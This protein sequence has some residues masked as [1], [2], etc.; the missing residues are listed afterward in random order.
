M[1]TLIQDLR[2]AA[3][4]LGNAPGFTAI[5]V[6]TLALG[7]GAVTAVFSVVNTV[8]LK[9]LPY[10]QPDR[11]V[12]VYQTFPSAAGGRGRGGVSVPN[13]RDWREQAGSL[14][15]L[16]AYAPRD[17][18][19]QGVDQ[20]QRLS[21]VA[22]SADLF[23]VLEA[24]PQLGRTF[25]AGE[26]EP[27][28][29]RA[30][31]LSDGF[32]RQRFDADPGIVGREL[33]LDGTTHTVVGVM[34]PE[35]RFPAA[36]SGVHLWV[37]LIAPPERVD[38]RGFNWLQVVGRL[39]PGVEH[40]AAQAEMDDVAR[41]IGE[42]DPGQE[43]VGVLILP[44][45]DVTVAN[46]RPTLLMLLGAAGLVLLIAGANTASLMLARSSGRRRELAVRAAL[47]ATPG[48]M[49]RQLL[50]ESLLLASAGGAAGLLL[51]SYA[52]RGMLAVAGGRLPRA[53]DMSLDMG[54]FAF[55]MVLSVACAVAFALLPALL[56]R[57][58][59]LHD[60]L[61]E[62]G[63]RG[64][65][66]GGGRGGNRFRGA[67]VVGQ[68]A[69]SLVLL[70]GAGLLVRT[71][72]VLLGT[73][74]GMR[75][76][77]VLTMHVAVPGERYPAGDMV[78]RFHAPALEQVQALPGV[79]AVGW[80]SHLPLDEWG[81][82]FWFEIPGRPAPA[83]RADQPFAEL[84][85]VSAGYFQALGI[86]VVQGRDLAPGDGL[87]DPVVLI[88]ST[89]ARRYFPD[90]DPTTQRIGIPGFAPDGGVAEIPIVGVVGDVRQ[91]ELALDP[92][93]EVYF[94]YDLASVLGIPK[95][96]LVVST[97]VPA[98]ILT[99]AVRRAIL[100]V[101]PDQ[102][103]YNVQTMEQ[104]VT[105]S[106]GDRRLYLWLLGAFALVALALAVAGIYGVM[107]YAVTQRTRE[108]SVRMALGA[109]P[110]GVRGLVVRQAAMLALLGVAVGV[111]AALGL[112]RLLQGLLHGVG[113]ADPVT[114][115]VVA[116]GLLAVALAAGY[117]PARRAS[118]VDPMVALRE[119]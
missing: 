85:L 89:L 94:P 20:P 22:V 81:T 114:F 87:H 86:P 99:G 16:A 96:T 50:V 80:T 17:A 117:L 62:G 44:L 42:L 95:F 70:V 75:T 84:R 102:P 59:R 2:Y 5:V 31:V 105:G 101:D 14:E 104:V 46:V 111:P 57:R 69:L 106:I 28:A 71:V 113:P 41:R 10:G 93:P 115:A 100:A 26:D 39:G 12:Q 25:L 55:L 88:N 30:V 45:T 79:R 8:L 64:G 18:N 107:S 48:R 21:T 76:E 61:K 56:A 74:T 90:D 15:S 43:E 73:E 19:L 9:P 51:A 109:S 4:S 92:M 72:S 78:Q 82:N 91:A 60:D 110:G 13:F 63:A 6:L 38:N 3:R 24:R 35:F 66:G 97:D 37:P 49:A 58:G 52:T 11:L 33:V 103:A 29:A 67:L 34:P 77:N 53:A 40:A 54:V 27:G 23:Q 36:W 83:S 119:E 98:T 116:S 32:W 65:G 1:G 118:R 7:L 108:I 47:G 68:F 112:T